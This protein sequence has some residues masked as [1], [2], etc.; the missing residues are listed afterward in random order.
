[1]TSAPHHATRLGLTGGIGSGKST[2]AQML[3]QRGAALVDADQIAR[4]VTGA[5][6]A[7]MADIAHTFGANFVDATGALDR[8]RMREHAFSQP[9]ARKQLEAIVHP[10]VARLSEARTQSALASGHQLVVLD[11]P[12][13]IESGHW[14]RQLGAVLV[15]DC[16]ES[17]QITRVVARNALTPT[18]VEA[19]MASQASR[20][21][22][23]AGADIVLYNDGLSLAALQAQVCLIAERF[24]L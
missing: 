14:P 6:G 23:R 18:A 8:A 24:G 19:I 7:A 16:Q 3:A 13:L 2:V 17:T 1:M 11:I 15:V 10:L 22:R 20:Q 12:L 4:E 21:Q 9:A 5:G